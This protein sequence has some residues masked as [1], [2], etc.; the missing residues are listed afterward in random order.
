MSDITFNC[1][2]CGT[3]IEAEATLAGKIIQCPKCRHAVKTPE[4]LMAPGMI[5]GGYELCMLLGKGGMG[6][7]WLAT[8][9]SMNRKVALKIL[10]VTLSKDPDLIARFN[11][12]MKTVAK[13]DHPGIVSAYEAGYSNSLYFLAT[14][15]VEGETLEEK[16]NSGKIFSEE[17]ALSIVRKVAEALMYA[18]DKYRILHRDI[19]P[20][21]IMIESGGAVKLMDLGIS[22]SL[23]DDSSI[24]MTGIIVGTPYYMSPEQAKAEKSIDLRADIYSLGATLYHMLTGKLPFDATNAMGILARVI[25]DSLTS[26]RVINP[27]V[28][29]GCEAVIT[30]MMAKDRMERQV[31]WQEVIDDIDKVLEGTPKIQDEPLVIGKN[32]L[33]SDNRL[34][35]ATVVLAMTVVAFAI[36]AISHNHKKP[37]D[38]DEE[39]LAAI[40]ENFNEPRDAN[41]TS[42]AVNTKNVAAPVV[43]GHSPKDPEKKTEGTSTSSSHGT[44]SVQ[45]SH[46]TSAETSDKTGKGSNVNFPA[47]HQRLGITQ[48]EAERLAPVIRD[49]FKEL[50][51]LREVKPAKGYFTL[52]ELKEK[53][54]KISTDTRNSAE[55]VVTKDQAAKLIQLLEEERKAA[56]RNYLSHPPPAS[57]KYTHSK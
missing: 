20:G 48:D 26:V 28:S 14:S 46:V 50:K 39:L 32:W 35:L 42:S 54:E 8:Q 43:A 18:W 13:L 47:L 22:K 40:N 9:S 51:Q 10:P 25:S 16:L 24:T 41:S 15:Y 7:V 52:A 3:E 38:S 57:T 12:E 4:N 36:F 5:L 45:P 31:S 11:N 34:K 1:L 19:K 6:E 21:N 33:F 56:F 17:E 23:K 30:K 37:V 27:R 49:Y 29:K 55:K 2:N 44:S 53:I